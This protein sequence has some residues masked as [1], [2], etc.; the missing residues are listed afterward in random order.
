MDYSLTTLLANIRRRGG[1]PNTATTGNQDSDLIAMIN[2]V[3]QLKLAAKLISVREG[4]MRQTQDTTLSQTAT[5]YRIPTRALGNKLAAVLTI[6]SGGNVL[7]KLDEI[8]YG[9]LREFYAINDCAGYV[10]EA[11]SIVLKPTK[12]SSTAV[13]L[14]QI[15]YIRPN[16]VTN[17]SSNYF[18]VT[19]VNTSTG[20]V[21]I[22]AHSFTT[23]SVIDV[24][25][26]SSPFEHVAISV[27]PT[28]TTGTTVTISDASQV[29]IGD[30]VCFADKSPVAQ[31][32]GEAYPLLAH[33][34]AMELLL[35]NGDRENYD[36]L[37]QALPKLEAE[38]TALISPRNEE[39]AKKIMSG[40]GSVGHVDGPYRRSFWGI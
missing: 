35:A 26:A 24:I 5:R 34:V 23:S 29:E 20:L 1:L 32:P 14:R 25:K 36:K 6:D 16:E 9:R 17:T 38:V 37:A 19:A 8:P 4:Y 27:N 18:T 30:Y 11:G 15:Y 2:E 13:T 22:G 10:F 39:G 33:L 3:L 31:I 21:T 40:Y 12:P 7:R 28:A